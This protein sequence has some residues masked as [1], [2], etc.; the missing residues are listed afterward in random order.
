[1]AAT[2]AAVNAAGGHG[3]QINWSTAE[4]C[5]RQGETPA[6]AATAIVAE[7]RKHGPRPTITGDKRRRASRF[8]VTGR[9]GRFAS[10]S[11]DSEPLIETA[12]RANTVLLKRQAKAA[13]KQANANIYHLLKNNYFHGIPLAEIYAAV[14]R[15]GLSVPRDEKDC[16]LTGRQGRATWPMT[17]H[18]MP[19]RE[20]LWITWYK[21]ETTGRY[22]VVGAIT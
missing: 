20:H 18:D 14:E 9:T 10:S 5:Y 15:T 7:Q 3:G 22:E 8:V 4:W 16:I 6:Q 11:R 2:Q 21:M 1:M 13:L 17:F 19:V 12:R